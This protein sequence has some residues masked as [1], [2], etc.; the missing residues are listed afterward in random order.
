MTRTFCDICG[1][2]TGRLKKR[3]ISL[4]YQGNRSKDLDVCETCSEKMDTEKR[5][6]EV[7]F[8]KQSVWWKQNQKEDGDIDYGKF[9][10]VGNCEQGGIKCPKCNHLNNMYLFKGKCER[11]GYEERK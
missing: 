9:K 3:T 6:A 11:C 8:L 10:S 7:D 2:E 5:K 4:T 1:N